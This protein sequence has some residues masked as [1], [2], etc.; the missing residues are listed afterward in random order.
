MFSILKSQ[1]K[2]Y[3]FILLLLR[4]SQPITR[5]KQ[6]FLSRIIEM[7]LQESFSETAQLL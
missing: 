3:S 4:E 1:V 5:L 6:F 7:E 2:R